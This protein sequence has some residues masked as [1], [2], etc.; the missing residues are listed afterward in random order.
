[1]PPQGS[2]PDPAP[3]EGV[4]RDEREGTTPRAQMRV[5]NVVLAEA[6]NIDVDMR[7]APKQWTYVAR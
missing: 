7:T 4:T 5:S 1:M 2:L 3:V 6:T